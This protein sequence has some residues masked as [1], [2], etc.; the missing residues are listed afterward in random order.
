MAVLGSNGGNVGAESGRRAWTCLWC[1]QRRGD[2]EG[3]GQGLHSR[4][5]NTKVRELAGFPSFH[6]ESRG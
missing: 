6:A 3:T 1:T 4:Y 2:G 5:R